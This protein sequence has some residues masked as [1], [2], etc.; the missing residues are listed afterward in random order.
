MKIYVIEDN[1]FFR[2]KL[3]KVLGDVIEESE[4]FFPIQ[5]DILTANDLLQ[6]DLAAGP[7]VYFLDIELQERLNGIDLGNEIRK[8]DI[9]GYIIYITSLEHKLPAIIDQHIAPLA[10]ISKNLDEGIVKSRIMETFDKVMQRE[11]VRKD[12]DFFVLN[13][14]GTKKKIPYQEILYFEKVPRSKKV[15][16]FTNNGFYNINSYLTSVKKELSESQFIFLNSFLIHI[17]AIEG[18]DAKEDSVTFKNGSEL[19]V[20]KHTFRKIKQ[21]FTL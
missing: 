2:Q 8:K 6:E 19:F 14:G 20:G 3:L 17:E 1:P 21:R 18:I 12:D 9:D 15:V 4:Y 11:R 13:R 5:D 7:H 16:L 10:F